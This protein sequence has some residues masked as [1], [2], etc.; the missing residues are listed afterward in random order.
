MVTL[1]SKNEPSTHPSLPTKL[2]PEINETPLF[3]SDAD[4]N[5]ISSVWA[6]WRYWQDMFILM[7]IP[8]CCSYRN[9]EQP[10]HPQRV[11]TG[12]GL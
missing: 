2:L 4:F 3:P 8:L 6:K 7:L 12:E 11:G 10:R 5:Q 9:E 1:S